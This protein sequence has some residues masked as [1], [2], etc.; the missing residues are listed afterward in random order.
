MPENAIRDDPIAFGLT[1]PQLGLA[2]A[3]AAVAFVLNLLPI[4]LPLRLGLAILVAAP[5]FGVAVISIRGEPGYRWLLRFVRFARSERRWFVPSA[6][7]GRPD[8]CDIRP[9]GRARPTTTAS[10]T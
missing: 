7:D 1:A 3:A 2:G 4:W 6:C 8:H 5:V 9:V 10:Y